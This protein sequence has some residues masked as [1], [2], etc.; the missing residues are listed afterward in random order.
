MSYPR[1][2]GS[3]GIRPDRRL[4]EFERGGKIRCDGNGIGREMAL[5][6]PRWR[7]GITTTRWQQALIG[8][9]KCAMMMKTQISTLS[10]LSSPLDVMHNE[11]TKKMATTF[12]SHVSLCANLL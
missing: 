2:V 4:K 6:M 10:T 1:G 5:A 7:E 9:T 11:S 8:F 12:V 3:G